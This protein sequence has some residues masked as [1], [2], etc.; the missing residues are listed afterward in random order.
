MN[1]LGK[2]A[3]DYKKRYGFSVIPIVPSTKKSLI[4]WEK[5]QTERATDEEILRWFTKYPESMIG[6]VTG[7]LSNL[8]IIDI[9]GLETPQELK[10]IL[11][12]SIDRIPSTRTPRGGR[13]LL[14]THRDGAR[15][16]TNIWKAEKDETMVDVRAEGSYA[17]LPP[18]CNGIGK[19][20]KWLLSLANKRNVFPEELLEIVSDTDKEGK[21]T[22]R[23]ISFTKGSRNDNIFHACNSHRR[24]G[25]PIEEARPIILQLASSCDPPL[26]EKEALASLD[27]AYKRG[28]KVEVQ[29][30]STVDNTMKTEDTTKT[31]DTTA[32]IRQRIREWAQIEV[33]PGQPFNVRDAYPIVNATTPEEKRTVSKELSRQVENNVLDRPIGTPYGNFRRIDDS[34]NIIDFKNASTER[35]DIKLPMDLDK[36]ITLSPSDMVIIAGESGAGKTSFALELMKVNLGSLK[37]LY[38]SS[39]LTG[40][41]MKQRLQLHEDI[42][43]DKWDFEMA[44]REQDFANRVEPDKVN[45]ID[46][47]LQTEEAWKAITALRE[48]YNKMKGGKGLCFVFLQKGKGKEFGWGGDATQTHA[49]LYLTISKGNPNYLKFVKVREFKNHPEDGETSNPLGK[50]IPF[51]LINSWK[52]KTL[53]ASPVYQSD[54]EGVEKKTWEK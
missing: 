33:A 40:G 8:N 12:D 47:L 25:M 44:R 22:I 26:S 14:F 13:H 15:G 21:P 50:V 9:D 53:V 28:S 52:F 29:T 2:V 32:E 42:D 38:I 24:S 6:V 48:I 18:S 37:C 30:S 34:K 27:S 20:Y 23:N 7:K 1:N 41:T 10:D 5:Y 54:Y 35:F 3:L 39:E 17:I 11:G 43:F 4:S 46:F 19:E 49:S 16:R 36:I 51:K 45:I 31:L